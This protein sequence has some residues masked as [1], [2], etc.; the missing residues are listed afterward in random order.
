[1][2]GKILLTLSSIVVLFLVLEIITR[3]IIPLASPYHTKDGRL[4]WD[5]RG[6]WLNLPNQSQHFSNIIDFNNKR[7][8]TDGAGLRHVPCRKEKNPNIPRIY[9]VGDSQT[10]GYGVNDQETWVN[11]LQCLITEKEIKFSVFNLGVPGTNIDQYIKRTK[12]FYNNLEKHDIVIYTITW[13]D[14]HTTYSKIPNFGISPTC[15]QNKQRYPIF[16]PPNKNKYTHQN[17]TWRRNLYESTGF[18][19]PLFSSFKEFTNTVVYTSSVASIFLPIIK[20]FYIQYRRTNTLE[21]LG[22]EIFDANNHLIRFIDTIVRKKTDNVI[23]A[24]LPGRISYVT[25]LY[26]LYSNKGKEFPEQDFL[27][28]FSEKSCERYS[29]NCFSLF[30]ALHAD[31]VGVHDYSHDGHLNGAGSKK[32]AHAVFNYILS[33]IPVKKDPFP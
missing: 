32:V 31:Q 33:N 5:Y 14:F 1:M 17:D 18:F 22:S 27:W 26:N 2:Y 15:T 29:L 30:Q 23:F 12:M 20:G 16:C 7:V 13:N 28:Y 8:R 25:E 3:N 10:F 4:I 6:F 9:I 24:F 21:I 11:Q 19:V